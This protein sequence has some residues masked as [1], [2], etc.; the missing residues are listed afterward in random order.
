MQEKKKYYKYQLEISI[1]INDVLWRDGARLWVQQ[2]KKEKSNINDILVEIS[3]EP[4]G[5]GTFPG[6]L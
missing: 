5:L 1:I 2:H 3:I 6:G 4:F